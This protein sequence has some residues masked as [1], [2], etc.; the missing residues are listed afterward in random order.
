MIGVGTARHVLERQQ[1]EPPK[2]AADVS[3]RRKLWVRMQK[4][5]E[6]S[7]RAKDLSPQD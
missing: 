5:V 3:P 1:C 4:E 6:P 2:E 7:E